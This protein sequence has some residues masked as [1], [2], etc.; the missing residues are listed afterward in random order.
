MNSEISSLYISA[1]AKV[2]F[3]EVSD[4]LYE[5][6]TQCM[7]KHKFDKCKKIRQHHIK[8]YLD[9]SLLHKMFRKADLKTWAL[10]EFRHMLWGRLDILG[11][12]I[13]DWQ[14]AS[15]DYLEWS[16]IE[17][18]LDKL[19]DSLKCLYQSACGKTTIF[20]YMKERYKDD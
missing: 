15:P 20:D 4:F 18:E 6:C 10:V 9:R 3:S 16:Y 12:H 8:M 5:T 2:L 7:Q 1:W 17:S 19:N 14:L 11:C 13:M